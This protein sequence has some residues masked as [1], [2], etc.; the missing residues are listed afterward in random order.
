MGENKIYLKL[1]EANNNT[2]YEIEGHPFNK[3]IYNIT[4]YANANIPLDKILINSEQFNTYLNTLNPEKIEEDIIFNEGI[5]ELINK[6]NNN[7]INLLEDINT[8]CIDYYPNKG[9]IIK[10]YIEKNLILRTKKS[11]YR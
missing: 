6:H 10:K 9:E 7:E 1:F 3:N 8:I 4:I 11:N 2:I 5:I